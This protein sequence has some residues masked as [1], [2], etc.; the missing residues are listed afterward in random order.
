MHY[1]CGNL[2]PSEC[3]LDAS[4]ELRNQFSD[5]LLGACSRNAID[6]GIIASGNNLED[7]FYSELVYNY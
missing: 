5:R 1:W 3:W 2:C 6:D 7:K 4:T